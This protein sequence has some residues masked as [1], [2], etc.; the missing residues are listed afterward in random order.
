MQFD[1]DLDRILPSASSVDSITIGGNAALNIPAGTT[2][3]RTTAPVAGSLRFSTTSTAFEFFNGTAWVTFTAASPGA[4][5]N[6][7]QYNSAGTFGGDAAFL[8]TPGVNP[9]VTITGPLGTNQFRVGGSTDI[10]GATVYIETNGTN[11]E[12]QRVYFNNGG[13]PAVSGYIGYA[14][15]TSTPYIKITDGDDDPT[16][17]TFDTIGT[18]TYAAPLYVSAFAARG[19]YGSRTLG[20]NSGFAWHIGANTSASALITAATPAMELDSQ[21]LRL[22]TGTTAQRP[23]GVNGMLRYNSTLTA[24]DFFQNGA[25]VQYFVLPQAS[26][27]TVLAGPVSGGPGTPTFRTLALGNLSDVVITSPST[28]Q[29]ISYNG[30]NW[31]NTGAVGS[32][33]TGLVGAGQAGAAAWTLISGSSFRA[34][35]AHNL[36]TTNVVI[37]VYDSATSVVVIPDLVT[38]TNTNTVRVQVTGNTRTLK[39]VVVANGQSIVAGGSTPSSIIAAKD[40]VTVG[41]TTTRLNFTGQSVRVSDAGANQSDVNIGARFTFFA[42][43]LDNPN[44]ADWA[45]NALAPVVTDPTYTSISQR[46][47]SNT[48]EQ[49]VGFFVSIPTGC[50][51]ATFRLRGRGQTAVAGT[52]VAQFRIRS[53]RIANGS[54]PA[55]WSAPTELTNI[56]VTNTIAFQYFTQ[57]V[58]FSAFSTALVADNMYL[59]ELT[60]RVTGVTGTNLAAN[61]FLTELT[62]EFS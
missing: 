30:T 36:G 56:S 14:Y 26:A 21:W 41:T 51:Q 3:Q 1:H 46:Q 19:A 50:T 7:V 54:A 42:N 2:A 15:D 34:D 38:C 60:R 33:A 39:V 23:T 16:Y 40:G 18:G 44:N 24:F 6:S 55:A 25:W 62:V 47:F 43:S 13:N 59:F 10:G 61:F 57:T 37:T 53:R 45:I 5:T 35:F 31:V 28:F 22:P 58:L 9:F 27:N 49:G 52:S 29:V 4:P 11:N 12:G 17:I 8:F 32:N 20:A 48:I